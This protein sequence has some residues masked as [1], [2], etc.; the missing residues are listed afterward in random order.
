MFDKPKLRIIKTEL[1]KR[2]RGKI[3]MYGLSSTRRQLEDT[4]GLP[5]DVIQKKIA[6]F[7]SESDYTPERLRQ[8]LENVN[9]SLRS[10]GTKKHRYTQKLNRKRKCLSKRRRPKSVRMNQVHYP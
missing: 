6:P 3:D 5:A 1:E 4:K 7:L 8:V 10:G 9:D 2:I